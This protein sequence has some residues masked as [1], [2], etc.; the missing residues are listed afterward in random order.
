MAL[1]DLHGYTLGHAE[2]L[3]TYFKIEKRYGTKILTWLYH[4][5]MLTYR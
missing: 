5:V 3:I 1:R 4:C 2:V